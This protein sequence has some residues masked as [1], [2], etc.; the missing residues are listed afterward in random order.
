MYAAESAERKRLFGLANTHTSAHPS[1]RERQCD[2][3]TYPPSET[4]G[5]F[6]FV[7]FFFKLRNR[8]FTISVYACTH[9]A[10]HTWYI[11]TVLYYAALANIKEQ[12][13][14]FFTRIA[15]RPA[16]AAECE[17]LLN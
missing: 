10:Q 11:Y 8:D 3:G 17:L 9:T 12:T 6:F 2:V 5:K 7:F 13:G 15:L 16:A 14:Q 4:R 1:G